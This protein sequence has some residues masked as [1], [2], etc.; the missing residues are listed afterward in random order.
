MSIS[1][2]KAAIHEA[3]TS[4][5][6]LHLRSLPLS[7]KLFL[8][9]LLARTRRTGVPDTTL[10]DVL[11]EAKRIADVAENQ[12]IHDFLLVDQRRHQREREREQGQGQGLAGGT[13]MVAKQVQMKTV[14]RV[15]AMGAAAME[16]L[17]SG[18]VAMEARGRGERSGKIR[19]RVGEEEVRGALRGDE[20]VR[21]LGFSG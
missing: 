21:G 8:A 19:L 14:P 9:A 10:G 5:L 18:V 16:L 4:P 20:E 11:I 3:T 15:L 12:A 1:T 2:I 6:S 13:A 17:A 7:S